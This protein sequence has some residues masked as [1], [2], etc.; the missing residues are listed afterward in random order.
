LQPTS[1]DFA[2]EWRPAV[3][4]E[5]LYEVSSDGRVASLSFR[6]KVVT[7]TRRK[8]LKQ[9][10]GYAGYPTV[11]LCREGKRH[12][13]RVYRIVASAF[14]GPKPGPG[15]LLAHWDGNPSNSRADNLRW[16]TFEGNEADKKRHGRNLAGERNH[17]AKLTPEVVVEIRERHAKGESAACLAR[18]HGL[19]QSQ[20]SEIVRGLSWTEAGG[21]LR[22]EG[23]VVGKAAQTHCKRGHEFTPE[24]TKRLK[25]GS[26][27][28]RA[29][30]RLRAPEKQRRRRRN[31]RER[32]LER[33]GF[34]HNTG[35]TRP[36]ANSL[37]CEVYEAT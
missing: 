34:I 16:T 18:S 35:R 4:F 24:N 30:A 12:S 36:N 26:R 3:G 32:E 9:T 21:P 2:I 27:M 1:S 7:K 37:Q 23:M 29:C 28:C 5:G 31:K 10:I 15:Y 25:S 14:L 8:E 20:V 17:Q 11:C 22:P 6:N 33:D 19:S 13:M